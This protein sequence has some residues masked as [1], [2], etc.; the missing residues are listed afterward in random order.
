MAGPLSHDDTNPATT[1]IDRTSH[2]RPAVTS[3]EEEYSMAQR[4]A[5]HDYYERMDGQESFPLA[6]AIRWGGIIIVTLI[7]AY[8]V[9]QILNTLQ[10]IF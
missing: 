2:S 7:V 9:V 1:R 8:L 4:R 10:A 6:T 3:K 5:D